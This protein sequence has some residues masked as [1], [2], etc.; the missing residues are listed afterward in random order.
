MR[1]N[2]WGG[3]EE[4][5]AKTAVEALGFGHEVLVSVFGW[6]TD[7]PKLVALQR[8]GAKIFRR[9]NPDYPESFGAHSSYRDLFRANPGVIFVS[10]GAIF[11]LTLYPDLL[12]LLSVTPIPFVIIVHCNDGLPMLS[13]GHAR[14]RISDVFARAFRVLFVANQ[15]RIDGE[16]Q[17]AHRIANAAVVLNPVN[18]SDRSYLAWP[19][20]RAARFASVARLETRWKGQDILIEALSTD[21]WK[22][23]DWH[24]TFYG[25]GRDEGYLRS[26]VEHFGLQRQITFAGYQNEV[27]AIWAKEQVLVMISRAEGIPL[28]LVEAMFCGRPAILTDVGG[29]QEWIA[30][31]QTGFVA[32]APAV[33]LARATLERAW[34]AR[35]RWCAMGAQA[36]KVASARINDPVFPNVLDVLLEADR[37]KSVTAS[38]QD[39]ER[40]MLYHELMEPKMGTRAKQFVRAGVLRLK[41][42][43]YR[44]ANTRA[45]V[46]EHSHG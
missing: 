13:N 39:L 24:L 28:A 1:G 12:E 5:W 38:D 3:S 6:T 31:P 22:E 16:R 35:Q 29:N 19:E 20:S 8:R 27:R 15:N 34:S 23:R 30:E 33:Q 9:Q 11:D 26:L 21:Q 36:H 45:E 2:P 37:Y 25:T 17:L 14:R 40:L 46:V 18:L 43:V 42:A 10:Q 7:P 41:N 44:W 32:E 4:L